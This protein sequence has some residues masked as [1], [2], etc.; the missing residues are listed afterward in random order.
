MNLLK[1][2]SVKRKTERRAWYVLVACLL[3]GS[4][5]TD[6]GSSVSESSPGEGSKPLTRI[7]LPRT[8]AGPRV[9]P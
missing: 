3:L 2:E 7:P 1:P 8:A 5:V 9:R 4:C 6:G